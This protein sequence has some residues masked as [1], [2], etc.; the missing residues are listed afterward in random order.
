MRKTLLVI[1][2]SVMFSGITSVVVINYY[3]NRKES[4]PMDLPA[5][6]VN[7]VSLAQQSYPDFTFAAENC[8]KAVVHVKVL[9]KGAVQ[10]YSLFD[11]FFGNGNPQSIQKE[12]LSAGSG[13]II[14]PDGYIVTNSH[15]VSGAEEISV[16]LESN[17]SYK[18]RLI[19]ADEVT[20][21][22]LVKIEASGLPYLEFGDSDALRLG[23]W[24]IA[25]GNPYNLTNTITAGIVSAKSRSMP[26][27]D[28]GFKIESFIQTDAAVNPGN[29]GGALVNIKGEL[30]GI[31]TAIASRTGSFTGYSF[32][33]PASIARKIVNDFVNFGEV[34][35]AMLG[36]TMQ[37]MSSELAREM[38]IKDVKGVY[39]GE[40]LNGGAAYK[41]GIKASDVI[42]SVNGKPVNSSPE[43]QEQIS[44]YRPKDRIKV[45]ILRKGKQK[46]L[47][48]VLEGSNIVR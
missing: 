3:E 6:Q 48:V 28:E 47:S 8:V 31:N 11:F 42:I 7:R 43:V 40:V 5:V 14:S 24:V 10:T 23:E 34:K 29:S 17:K 4:A 13:V 16:T 45:G 27:Y 12:Q 33:V 19:G 35:R 44:K 21:I 15:V 36:I 38:G 20:D 25:I 41:A 37:D 18:A 30:V 39:I 46:E 1:I 26:S 9:S 32:A 22:A 2:L